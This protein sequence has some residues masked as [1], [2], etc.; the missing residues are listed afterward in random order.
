MKLFEPT[1]ENPYVIDDKILASFRNI[2]F[3]GINRSILTRELIKFNLN[4]NHTFHPTYGGGLIDEAVMCDSFDGYNILFGK[5]KEYNIQ[6]QI[7]IKLGYTNFKPYYNVKLLTEHEDEF[8]SLI[9]QY[10]T[11]NSNL[12][13]I[14]ILTLENENIISLFKNFLKDCN[15]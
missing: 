8:D 3:A 6:T 2:C 15:V 10:W 14:V 11:F 7:F 12:K 13:E 4:N 1:F 5:P 9:E